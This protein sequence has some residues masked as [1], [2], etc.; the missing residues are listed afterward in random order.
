[1][2]WQEFMDRLSKSDIVFIA[3]L[4]TVVF[5]VLGYAMWDDMQYKKRRRYTNGH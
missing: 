3:I 4:M 5:G 2:E 1:M